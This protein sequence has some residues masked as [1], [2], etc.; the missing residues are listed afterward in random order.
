M[1]G[2]KALTDLLDTVDSCYGVPGCDCVITKDGQVVYRHSAGFSDRESRRPVSPRDTYWLYSAGK[3][4]TCAGALRLVE[5]G[6]LALEDPV[7]RY[8]PEFGNLRVRER[9]GTVRPAGTVLTVR[10][11]MTM[12]GGLDYDLT[13]PALAQALT[14]PEEKRTTRRI[15]AAMAQDPLLFDPGTHFQYSLCHDVL[16]A[17]MEAASGLPLSE[18]L[19]REIFRPLG[20][21]DTTFRPG[22]EL[23]DRMA[24]Q[25]NHSDSLGTCIPWNQDNPYRFGKAYDSGG[26]GLVSTADDYIRFLTALSLGGTGTNGYRVL[27]PGSVA[28]M[29]T[30]ELDSVQ[31]EDFWRR[32]AAMK[33][34]SYGL[35]VRVLVDN[36]GIAST[37]GEFGWDGSAG[38]YA[39]VDPKNR[40]AM[41]YVQH[42]FSCPIVYQQL[43]PRLRDTA[44]KC[45]KAVCR[46]K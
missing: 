40:I 32:S 10:H 6:I 15:V 8:L 5:A 26:A 9:D 41:F 16:G 33:G 31:L 36:T 43:H 4:A 20:M 14:L 45:W 22:R 13:R 29:A 21:E 3:L 30:P 28:A 17:V 34:Y 24:T 23:M 42:V 35:G 2:W 38:A 11:L 12:T 27:Q 18:L 7:S 39:L 25:Y 19:S 44:F 46:L 37:P 1:D